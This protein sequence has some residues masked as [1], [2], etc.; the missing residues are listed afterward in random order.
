[1][2]YV[3][4]DLKGESELRGLLITTS[5]GG[6]PVYLRDLIDLHRGYESPPTYLNR[7][8]RR[9]AAPATSPERGRNTR[10]DGEWER[11]RAITLGVFMRSGAQ[12]VDF[13]T[14]VDATLADVP[15]TPP[16]DLAIPRTT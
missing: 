14:Q 3:S 5:T 7:Y 11:T 8:T 10:A 6:Q 4:E 16:E 1:M 12:I 13:G 2:I 9:G 15:R